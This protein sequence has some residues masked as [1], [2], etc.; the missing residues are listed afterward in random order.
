MFEWQP[1]LDIFTGYI[2][3]RP[4]ACTSSCYYSF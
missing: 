3:P 2:S 1:T 4:M